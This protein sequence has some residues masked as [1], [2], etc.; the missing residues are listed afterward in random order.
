M[1]WIAG[2]HPAASPRLRRAFALRGPVA[3][4]RLYLCGQGAYEASIEEQ[5]VSDQVLGPTLSHFA[6]RM[7][8]D[9]FDV[10]A[11]LQQGDNAVGVW[12]APGWFGDPTTWQKM[13]MPV[14]PSAF[15]NPASALLAQIEVRYA[16]GSTETICSDEHWTTAPSPLVP[17]RSHW[18]YCFGFSGETYDATQE[19]L[20]W[21]A[22]GFNDS[23]WSRVQCMPMPT[24][25]VRARMVEPNRI[26]ALAKPDGQERID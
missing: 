24:A 14:K 20:G 11:L 19:T 26:R 9:T 15:P 1:R 13:P 16:D 21:D 10:T 2:G 25:E 6:N 4:A 3:S 22:P 5:P 7:L 18:T 8:Y 23:D 12:L 17:V